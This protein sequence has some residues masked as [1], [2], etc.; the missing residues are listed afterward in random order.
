[1]ELNREEPTESGH[2]FSLKNSF[3][4][5]IPSTYYKQKLIYYSNILEKTKQLD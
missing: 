1:M 5:A 2:I 3:I 4:I